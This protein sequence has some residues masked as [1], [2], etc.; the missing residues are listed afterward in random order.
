MTSASETRPGIVAWLPAAFIGV[1]GLF[2]A[3]SLGMRPLDAHEA[4]GVFPMW[5]TQARTFETA[6][7]AGRIVSVGAA[8]FV[9]IVRSDRPDVAQALRAKGA[10]LV[11]D[12][13]LAAACA[14]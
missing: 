7:Q 6:A 9:V 4:A 13:G 11:I 1:A 5:W 3:A 10:W 2:A 8:P 12:P 14:S